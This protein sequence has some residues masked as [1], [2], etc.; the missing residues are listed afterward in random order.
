MTKNNIKL[1]GFSLAVTLIWAGAVQA[2][3]WDFV[4]EADVYPLAEDAITD[5][6]CATIF[7]DPNIT[8][9]AFAVK[10]GGHTTLNGDG[11]LTID[12]A[13]SFGASFF[14]AELADGLW[15]ITEPITVGMRVKFVPS[16]QEL[17]DS[18]VFLSVSNHQSGFGFRWYIATD[19]RIICASLT[20]SVG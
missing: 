6:N 2:V 1:I 17:G 5:A 7:D 10:G 13:G 11:T 8:T 4:Y 19:S 12:D 16:P 18:Y 15:S 20:V 9:G 14:K 3:K